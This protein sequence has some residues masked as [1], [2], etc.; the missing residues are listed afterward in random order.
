MRRTAKRLQPAILGG[1]LLVALAPREALAYLDP[2]FGSIV[3]Q[4]AIAAFF[5]AVY[6]VKQ[7]WARIR[8]AARRLVK[9]LAR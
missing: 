1:L 2:S 7:Q 8:A 9:A 6:V 5:A 3:F 4:A